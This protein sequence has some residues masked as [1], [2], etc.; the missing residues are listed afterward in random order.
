MNRKTFIH[1]L[2]RGGI[3]AALAV[4]SGTLLSRRQVRL[5]RDCAGELPCRSCRKLSSCS[6]PEAEKERAYEKG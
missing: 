3:L 1:Q 4:L 6:L 5:E 2:V